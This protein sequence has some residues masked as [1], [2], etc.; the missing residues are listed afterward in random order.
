MNRGTIRQPIATTK[1]NY[2]AEAS[3]VLKGFRK[4]Q[5]AKEASAVLEGYRTGRAPLV[6][7][8]KGK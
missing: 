7:Y 3:A 8:P 4:S 2:K 1:P 6:Q 5:Y